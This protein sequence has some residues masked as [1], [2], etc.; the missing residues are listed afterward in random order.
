MS[1]I[2]HQLFNRLAVRLIRIVCSRLDPPWFSNVINSASTRSQHCVQHRRLEAI[3]PVHW[4]VRGALIDTTTLFQL[5]TWSCSSFK[6]LFHSFQYY[7][8]PQFTFYVC[9]SSGSIVTV[10]Y[11][12]VIYYFTKIKKII[13]IKKIQTNCYKY[14]KLFHHQLCI[15][16]YHWQV[17]NTGMSVKQC[18]TGT[19]V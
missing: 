9:V 19:G 18:I 5:E 15:F 16:Q 4:S 10:S 12:E 1:D 8:D 2:R 11:V 14:R 6:L 7:L 3:T 17:L 13:L